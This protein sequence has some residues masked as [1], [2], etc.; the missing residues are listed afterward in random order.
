[1]GGARV[2]A[3]KPAVAAIMRNRLVA[4]LLVLR[5]ARHPNRL[6]VLKVVRRNLMIWTTIFRFS[7][8]LVCRKDGV[9]IGADKVKALQMVST[10]VLSGQGVELEFK[11]K[12]L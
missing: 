3:E 1:M 7:T 6:V 8:D 12:R 5:L 4:V 10:L 2:W 9:E 11:L